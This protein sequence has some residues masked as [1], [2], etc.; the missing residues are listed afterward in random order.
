VDLLY[1]TLH[2]KLYNRSATVEF[3]SKRS[4]KYRELSNINSEGRIPRTTSS[5]AA[6]PWV[7]V[8]RRGWPTVVTSHRS[9]VTLIYLFPVRSTP[10][11][12]RQTDHGQTYR[13]V[14]R[15]QTDDRQ[16]DGQTDERTV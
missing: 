15:R 11:A 9:L 1:N 6:W 2:R 10:P 14:Y 7:V 13:P 3:G 4:A 12:D 5:V 8:E 16:T